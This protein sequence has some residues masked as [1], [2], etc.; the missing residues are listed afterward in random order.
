VYSSGLLDAAV[1]TGAVDMPVKL[2]F[3]E[4]GTE[5]QPGPNGAMAVPEVEAAG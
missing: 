1:A 2:P 4:E 5:A 3:P